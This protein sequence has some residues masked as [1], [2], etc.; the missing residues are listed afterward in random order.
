MT[1]AAG[2]FS[3]TRFRLWIL[4]SISSRLTRVCRPGH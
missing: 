1:T 4:A 3:V 2:V